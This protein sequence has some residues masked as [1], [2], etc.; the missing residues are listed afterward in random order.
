LRSF[1][2]VAGQEMF[3]DP[4]FVLEAAAVAWRGRAQYAVEPSD[5]QAERFLIPKWLQDV[6]RMASPAR[7]RAQ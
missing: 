4:D 7:G 5:L 2:R 3:G 1:A 6:V